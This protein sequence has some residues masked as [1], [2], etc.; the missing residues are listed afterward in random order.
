[1]EEGPAMAPATHEMYACAIN[2]Q[3]SLYHA[4]F[5]VI[6]CGHYLPG[7]IASPERPADRPSRE[8]LLLNATGFVQEDA[9]HASRMT[10]PIDR[11][12]PGA[13]GAALAGP[14]EARSCMALLVQ[15]EALCNRELIGVREMS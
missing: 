8:C 3:R 1:M 10:R 4:P 15:P 6:P 12:V 9:L 13:A 11:A 2:Q 5:C 14:C 7:V